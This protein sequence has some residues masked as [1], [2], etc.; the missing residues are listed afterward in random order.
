[1]THPLRF[2]SIQ[3]GLLIL[4]LLGLGAFSHLTTNNTL[5]TKRQH[6]AWFSL[7]EDISS[8]V[9]ELADTL[10]LANNASSGERSQLLENARTLITRSDDIIDTLQHTRGTTGS[11]RR[12]F[13]DS[14]II[15]TVDHVDEQWQSCRNAIEHDLDIISARTAA[16]SAS[17]DND[18]PNLH[19][20]LDRT[21]TLYQGILDLKKQAR[22]IAKAEAEDA[23]N[24][25][26]IQALAFLALATSCILVLYRSVRRERADRIVR[27]EQNRLSHIVANTADGIIAIDRHGTALHMNPAAEQIFDYKA[28]EVLGHNIKMLM[29]SPHHENHDNYLS[30]YLRTGQVH[31]IGLERELEARRKDGTTVP[32]ALRV[33]EYR[34]GEEPLFIGIIQNISERVRERAAR[35][36]TIDTLADTVTGLSS[37]TANLSQV[38]ISQSRQVQDQATAI[39]E[40]A[41]MVDEIVHTAQQAAASAE[42]VSAA[43]QR[44]DEM[45]MEGRSAIRQT[46][47]TMEQVRQ[48]SEQVAASILS[49]SER[50]QAI[51]EIISTVNGI[52]DQ[53]NLLSLNAGIEASRAG[54][55]GRG[56]SVVAARI[57]D[58]A[59]QSKEATNEIQHILGEIQQATNKAVVD[60]EQGNLSVQSA[61]QAMGSSDQVIASLVEHLSST[62]DRGQHIATIATQQ[63][64]GMRQMH[65]AVQKISLSSQE[66]LRTTNETERVTKDLEQLSAL[67]GKILNT[68]NNR[69]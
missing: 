24:L 3:L 54:E 36:Q 44:A 32:I 46:T 47:E 60:T 27:I 20:H 69:A 12:L 22:L 42:E 26:I 50:A 17:T 67:I 49:L 51:G 64:Q 61:L 9:F 23:S 57:K 7:V 1:M 58:L 35:S 29:P 25:L 30:A 18:L 10:H 11:T 65:E 34:A 48:R 66:S 15:A 56:F 63:A 19:H 37:A 28:S 68:T 45:G 16:E 53:T 5:T 8:T 2:T 43:S 33:S 52:A 38:T 59:D 6:H 40:A 62:C 4:A 55:H 39:T 14:D 21:H 13:D 41:A 31:I